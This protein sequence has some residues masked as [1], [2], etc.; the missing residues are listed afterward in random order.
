MQSFIIE[1]QTGCSEA[2][3]PEV[4]ENILFALTDAVHGADGRITGARLIGHS[5]DTLFVAGRK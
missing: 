5:D 2:E 4:L 1:V 3:R